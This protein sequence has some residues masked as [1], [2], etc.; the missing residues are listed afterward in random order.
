VADDLKVHSGLDRS[1]VDLSRPDEVAYW[2]ERLGI[3]EVELRRAV[4][5]VGDETQALREHF[6]R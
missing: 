6:G 2:T 3:D 1:R 5:D 4:A